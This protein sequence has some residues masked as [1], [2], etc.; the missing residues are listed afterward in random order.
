MGSNE[1]GYSFNRNAVGSRNDLWNP[2]APIPKYDSG[3]SIAFFPCVHPLSQPLLHP[4]PFLGDA[5]E[6]HAITEPG[7]GVLGCDAKGA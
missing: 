4:Q 2:E 6:Q 1:G 3:L 7:N 5:V